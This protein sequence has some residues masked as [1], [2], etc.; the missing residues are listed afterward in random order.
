MHNVPIA[1]NIR[2]AKYSWLNAQ[3]KRPCLP[4]PAVQAATTKKTMN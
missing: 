2:R 4:L 3:M 1:G